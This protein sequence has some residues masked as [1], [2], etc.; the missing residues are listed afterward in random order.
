MFHVGDSID[1]DVLAEELQRTERISDIQTWRATKGRNDG[2]FERANG[3]LIFRTGKDDPLLVFNEPAGANVGRSVEVRAC[4]VKQS[5]SEFPEPRVW[6][7]CPCSMAE[8][9]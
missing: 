3:A 1:Q 8:I 9:Q 5:A 7:I 6:V 2:R 4:S